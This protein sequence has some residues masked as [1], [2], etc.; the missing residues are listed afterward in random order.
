M[1]AG[2]AV[3]NG[4]AGNARSVADSVGKLFGKVAKGD[5]VSC[6]AMPDHS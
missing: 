4:A 2:E 6:M 5:V 3:G 1:A